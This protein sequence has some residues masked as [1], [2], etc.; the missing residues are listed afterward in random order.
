MFSET[1]ILKV[2]VLYV[3]FYNSFFGHYILF[4][5]INLL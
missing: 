5:F 2:S 4:N 3:A 1:L